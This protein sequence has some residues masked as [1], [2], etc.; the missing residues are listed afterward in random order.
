MSHE[1]GGRIPPL[2]PMRL[3]MKCVS[4]RGRWI[5]FMMQQLMRPL[6]INTSFPWHHKFD[7]NLIDFATCA[8][9][10]VM[11]V[12]TFGAER[13]YA[14]ILR[15]YIFVAAVLSPFC[16]DG[17]AVEWELKLRSDFRSTG[18]WLLYYMALAKFYFDLNNVS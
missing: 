11:R 12:N 7:L 14:C 15:Y 8:D 6:W 5:I 10:D 1:V 13:F 3:W 4:L 17:D 18:R 9:N 2:K 16:C